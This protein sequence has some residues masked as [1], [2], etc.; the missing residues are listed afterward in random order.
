MLFREI[1][2]KQSAPPPTLEDALAEALLVVNTTPAPEQPPEKPRITDA[3]VN[4][5][6]R[7]YAH[8]DFADRGAAG[9]RLVIDVQGI[10]SDFSDSKSAAAERISTLMDGFLERGGVWD[11]H[12]FQISTNSDT[13]QSLYAVKMVTQAAPDMALDHTVQTM[14]RVE[15]KQRKPGG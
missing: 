12:K 11:G 1:F 7:K 10:K 9:P 15:I 4:A 3:V 8:M 2:E 13:V 6:C 5:L 14:K